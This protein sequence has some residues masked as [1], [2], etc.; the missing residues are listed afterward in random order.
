MT[1]ATPFPLP[2]PAASRGARRC[3]TAGGQGALLLLQG[4]P[5]L[6]A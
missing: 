4:H 5:T 1:A 3:N 6:P 2:P